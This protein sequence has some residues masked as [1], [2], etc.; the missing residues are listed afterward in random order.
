MGISCFDEKHRAP[1][2]KRA[3]LVGKCGA[4]GYLLQAVSQEP[5]FTGVLKLPHSIVIQRIVCHH[6]SR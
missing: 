6:S 5:R 1:L 2:N 3:V 4:N